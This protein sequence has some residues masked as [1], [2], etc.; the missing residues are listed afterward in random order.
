VVKNDLRQMNFYSLNIP[1]N[2][3]IDKIKLYRSLT[4]EE[5]KHVKEK[6]N[7]DFKV[8]TVQFIDY[9]LQFSRNLGMEIFD[10]QI[11]LANLYL[12]MSPIQRQYVG[13]KLAK[14]PR[15]MADYDGDLFGFLGLKKRGYINRPYDN[16]NLLN[17]VSELDKN[18]SIRLQTLAYNSKRRQNTLNFLVTEQLNFE[19]HIRHKYNEYWTKFI[20]D[21]RMISIFVIRLSALQDEVKSIINK[22]Y[23]AGDLYVN[24][25]L[26][27]ALELSFPTVT[28]YYEKRSKAFMF[29]NIEKDQM[30]EES[31]NLDK[32]IKENFM[33]E[34][35][36]EYE[37]IDDKGYHNQDVKKVMKL[38]PQL[39][40]DIK[41]SLDDLEH[42][43]GKLL[44][45]VLSLNKFILPKNCYFDVLK[46]HMKSKLTEYANSYFFYDETKKGEALGKLEDSMR[47]LKYVDTNFEEKEFKLWNLVE[48]LVSTEMEYLDKTR[49]IKRFFKELEEIF[50]IF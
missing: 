38:D 33:T 41:N 19:K 20:R 21:K 32:K 14:N 24:K 37:K 13:R 7:I 6:Y 12:S 25:Y 23:D 49:N 34:L 10:K 50:V 26:D 40:F 9:F 18:V 31:K 5:R 29:K 42:Y 46:E 45:K 11:E 30:T 48:D 43:Q 39:D 28:D 2:K 3:Q 16:V 22:I 17:S 4:Q 35:K 15:S 36:K 1:L 27:R 44:D 47:F 8:N